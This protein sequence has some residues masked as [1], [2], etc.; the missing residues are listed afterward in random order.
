MYT[1]D[2]SRRAIVLAVQTA[3][4]GDDEFARSL[5]ELH[6]LARTLG[7]EVVATLTQKRA[8][9]DSV[10]YLG[11]GKR[12]EL[13]QLVG[14]GGSVPEFLLHIKNDEAW[15]RWSDEPF[16]ECVAPLS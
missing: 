14:D 5:A 16:S 4:V 2:T 8:A 1:I 7:V 9:F 13:K 6:Q 10:A 3:G 15:F 11:K 12:E